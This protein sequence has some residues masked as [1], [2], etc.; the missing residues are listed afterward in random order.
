MSI[1]A[2]NVSYLGYGPTKTSEVVAMSGLRGS[3]AQC[4][5]G[6]ATFTGDGSAST[7]TLNFVD[8]VQTIF[9]G[10]D[11]HNIIACVSGGTDANGRG[12]LSIVPTGTGLSAT[13][14]WTGIVSAA[15]TSIIS[16]ILVK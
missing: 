5:I 4:L 3:N 9:G 8:G 12:V 16:L 1:A 6:T 7:A 15:G 14:T 13:V 2:A 10:A 11:P